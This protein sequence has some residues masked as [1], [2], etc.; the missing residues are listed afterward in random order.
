MSEK[1]IQICPCEPDVR[2][3]YD[4]EGLLQIY[5][6]TCLAIIERCSTREIVY[7]ETVDNEIKVVD[8]E[9]KSFLGFLSSFDADRISELEHQLKQKHENVKP[10]QQ[11]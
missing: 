1:I 4:N 11:F 9:D 7:M 2:I 10:K 6:P 3:A 5:P 8:T